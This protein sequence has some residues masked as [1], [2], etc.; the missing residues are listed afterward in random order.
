MS[1][2]PYTVVFTESAKPGQQARQVE[3]KGEIT[4]ENQPKALNEWQK[5]FIARLLERHM[6]KAALEQINWPQKERLLFDYLL[7]AGNEPINKTS[8]G[9]SLL[10]NP[11]S[12]GKWSSEKRAWQ[13]S[14]IPK[15][16]K[17]TIKAL[18]GTGCKLCIAGIVSSALAGGGA[19]TLAFTGVLF[20]LTADVSSLFPGEGIALAATV[21]ALSLLFIL[22]KVY[23]KKADT[24]HQNSLN[25]TP[26]LPTFSVSQASILKSRSVTI[27]PA[28]EDTENKTDT[29]S[30]KTGKYS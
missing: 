6:L 16:T 11:L 12:S 27:P 1:K 21:V 19:F 22:A 3:V 26:N 23:D 20:V 5:G 18:Y 30:P 2:R 10:A 4:I 28:S 9:R 25:N 15:E 13:D 8:P 24:A 29:T 17:T 7:K 14:F